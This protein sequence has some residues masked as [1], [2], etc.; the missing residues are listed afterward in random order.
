MI[1]SMTGYGRGQYSNDGRQYTVEIRTINHRFL[2]MSIK[3]SRNLNYLEDKVR[4]FLSKYVFRGKIDVYISMFNFSDQGRKVIVDSE[5]A[6]MYVK[7]L[8]Q[9]KQEQGL[10]DE[11]TLSLVSKL[12][13]V[14]NV[15]NDQNEELI[16]GELKEALTIAVDNLVTMREREGSRLKSDILEKANIIQDISESI[17][18]KAPNVVKE[19][20]EKLEVRIKELLAGITLDE[21]RIAMEVALFSDKCS[22]SGEITRLKS[23]I[24]QLKTTLN[25]DEPV[26]KKLDF[27][28]QE[29]NRE[30]N[31][32]GSK[33]NN[34][35]ITQ[36]V[37][38]A[39]NQIE[40][41]REQIQN[42]E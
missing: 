16:W 32:I 14:L 34:L 35:K 8:N 23:H 20:K 5:L 18:I 29:L 19:Y 28:L 2:D 11:I 27:L 17:D 3:M 30:V 13:D 12:A 25:Q 4:Q 22:I 15:E 39:K 21:S 38:E 1:K 33:A 37:L 10:N 40:N 6:G 7:A 31:T 41:I 26:G 42:I 24:S 36:Y 9:L